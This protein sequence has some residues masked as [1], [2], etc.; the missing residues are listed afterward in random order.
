MKSYL[1]ALANGE[2]LGVSEMS[3]AAGLLFEDSVSD[4]EIAALLMGLKMKGETS[5]EIAGFVEALRRHALTF[6]KTYPGIIDNCGTG[7]D[8]SHSFNI[9]TTSAFVLAGAG[10]KVAKHGNRSVS[11]KTGSA[12]VLDALGVALDFTVEEVDE[13]LEDNGIS[14]LFAPHVHPKIKRIMKVRQDLKV[15]TVFNLLGPLINPVELDTQLLGIYQREGLEM[16][17]QALHHL[18]RKRA[19]V[20]NGAGYMD[21]ASLAGENH[22]ILLADGKLQRFTFHPEELGLNTYPLE[23]IKGGNAHDNAEILLRVL[24]GEK[25]AP[26]ETVL[27]NSSLALL[28]H[29]TAADLKE[30]IKLAEDSIQSGAALSK[31]NYLIEFSQKRKEG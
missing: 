27:L 30:G 7:G 31:L 29:G 1:E 26:Y 15:P 5:E 14:F 6:S 9:S 25:G 18:G 21:E 19:V 20:L 4:S 13:L 2:N 12:D 8:G 23:A 22:A 3:E 17:A 24:K 16:M 28:A 10:L 11:S